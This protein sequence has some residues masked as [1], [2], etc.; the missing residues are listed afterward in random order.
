M[1]G[2]YPLQRPEPSLEVMAVVQYI[3]ENRWDMLRAKMSPEELETLRSVG[4]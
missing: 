1:A 2:E 3:V 4:A